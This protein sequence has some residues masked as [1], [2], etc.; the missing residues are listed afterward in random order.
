MYRKIVVNAN[1]AHSHRSRL[2]QHRIIRT[3]HMNVCVRPYSTALWN[4]PAY[5]GLDFVSVA[6]PCTDEQDPLP[7]IAGDPV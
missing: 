3:R 2:L 5:G 4:L 6:D 1:A 7:Q